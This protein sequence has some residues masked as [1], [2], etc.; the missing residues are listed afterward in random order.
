MIRL[1]L[2][3]LGVHLDVKLKRPARPEPL[4]APEVVHNHDADIGFGFRPDGISDRPPASA[5]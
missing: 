3:V 5:R 1:R 2:D 4:P